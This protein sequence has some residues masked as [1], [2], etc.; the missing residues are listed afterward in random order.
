MDDEKLRKQFKRVIKCIGDSVCYNE[1]DF[2]EYLNKWIF[3]DKPSVLIETIGWISSKADI[4]EKYKGCK[5]FN[6]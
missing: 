1:N 5:C 6:F 4:P 3:P 2:I